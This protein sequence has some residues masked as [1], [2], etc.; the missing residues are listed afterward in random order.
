MKLRV[1]PKAALDLEEASFYYELES[2]EEL[3]VRFESAVAET[4]LFLR[5]NPHVGTLTDFGN[6]R[7]GNLRR[8]RVRDFESYLVFHRLDDGTLEV[9]RVLHGAR[10]LDQIFEDE[11]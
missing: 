7:L 1:L 11:G 8:W 2:G 3:A 6:P 5:K 10:D 4:F 9:V